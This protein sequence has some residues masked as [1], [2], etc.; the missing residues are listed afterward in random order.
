MHAWRA[1]RRSDERTTDRPP[2]AC[3]ERT[4]APAKVSSSISWCLQLRKA[5]VGLPSATRKGLV[6]ALAAERVLP[7]LKIA[8]Y[9]QPR[10]EVA[11]DLRWN[12]LDSDERKAGLGAQGRRS[13]GREASIWRLLGNGTPLGYALREQESVHSSACKVQRWCEIQTLLFKYD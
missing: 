8:G 9:L 1:R 3:S 5:V 11:S 2:Q 4:N 6:G 12:C 7:R 10:H 13:H